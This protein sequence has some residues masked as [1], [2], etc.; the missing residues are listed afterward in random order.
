MPL[1]RLFPFINRL[2][3]G[4]GDFSPGSGI[5]LLPAG[6]TAL[7]TLICYEI[8]FPNLTRQFVRTGRTLYRQHNQ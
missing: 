6:D 4:I 3:T 8:I 2:V 5:R 7:A 1:Q